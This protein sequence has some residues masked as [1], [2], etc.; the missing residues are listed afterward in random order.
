M[1]KRGVQQSAEGGVSVEAL[2]QLSVL[3]EPP[4]TSGWRKGA[5]KGLSVTPASDGR[6]PAAT[7]AAAALS[8]EYSE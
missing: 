4:A 8:A 6:M 1:R 3:T 2:S 5:L 7:Q